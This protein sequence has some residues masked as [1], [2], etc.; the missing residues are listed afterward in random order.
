VQRLAAAQLDAW[1]RLVLVAVV[2]VALLMTGLFRLAVTGYPGAVLGLALSALLVVL[3]CRPG[4][5]SAETLLVSSALVAAVGFIH[6]P[7]LPAALLVAGIW[8]V[9]QRARARRHPGALATLAVAAVAGAVVAAVGLAHA[10]GAPAIAGALPTGGRSAFMI[11]G[12]ALLVGL[13]GSAPIRS[14]VWRSFEWCV[15]AAVAGYLLVVLVERLAG[16]GMDPTAEYAYF[17]GAAVQLLLPMAILGLGT[18]LWLRPIRRLAPPRP[19]ARHRARPTTT[20][21]RTTTP[22]T[23]VAVAGATVVMVGAAWGIVLADTAANRALTNRITVAPWE[24]LHGRLADTDAAALVAAGLA[25][26]VTGAAAVVLGED[27]Q[28]AGRA[29]TMLAA[30]NRTTATLAIS[31]YR[32]PVIHNQWL[33]DPVAA[34]DVEAVRRYEAIIAQVTGPVVLVYHSDRTRQWAERLEEQFGARIAGVVQ[35]DASSPA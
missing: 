19:T 20:T 35:A 21:P 4:G 18:L 32:D 10:R 6:P 2:G 34:D 24:F 15:G 1:R 7:F 3:V 33:A 12:A 13:L 31:T 30:L 28:T 25:Q 14:A 11:L 16:S 22:R 8:V 9:R 29:Q 23:T 5:S 26:P 27:W 17:G